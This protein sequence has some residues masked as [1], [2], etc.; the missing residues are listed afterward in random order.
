[1]L[2][3]NIQ[4]YLANGFIIEVE[5]TV[6]ELLDTLI[7]NKKQ[8]I[9]VVA[10]GRSKKCIGVVSYGDLVRWLSSNSNYLGEKI[11]DQLSLVNM[12]FA[13]V[14]HGTS[15]LTLY[16]LLEKFGSIPILNDDKTIYKLIYAKKYNEQISIAGSLV[17]TKSKP[18]YIAEIGNNHN[19]D[20][21]LARDL[22]HAAKSSGANAIKFQARTKN[23]YKTGTTDLGSEYV[24]D[25]VS[26]FTLDITEL[27]KLSEEARSIGLASIITPFDIEA[28][29]AIN[30][31]CWDAIKIASVDLVNFQLIQ[32]CKGLSLPLILSTGM[33]SE[34]NIVDAYDLVSD[35]MPG[36]CFLH[37]NSTYPSPFSDVHLEFME[38]LKKIVG[39][40][41][42]Y[43]G[44]ELGFHVANAAIVKGACIVEKHFTLDKN[45]IGNDHKVSLLPLEFK[46]MVILGHQIFEALGRERGPTRNISQGE[47]INKKTLGKSYIYKRNYECGDLLNASDI[48]QV[49]SSEGRRLSTLTL[50][51]KP[52]NRN[53]KKDNLVQESDFWKIATQQN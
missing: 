39:P 43:S 35:H 19:G 7:R 3:N 23:L 31:S 33:S 4:D 25:L 18:F 30:R 16:D 36:F 40:M 17:S 2:D 12:N 14:R 51:G 21:E 1:M 13:Y 42:G 49:P 32:K 48:I 53:V 52:F 11:K 15:E 22:V 6:R 26:R 50:S 41:V 27:E 47:K 8:T 38:T 34:Q 20:F 44:H 5:K 46:K 29:E 45:M 28:L 9:Y 10:S 24:N 37:C